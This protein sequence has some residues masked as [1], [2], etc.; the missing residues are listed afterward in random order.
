M[1]LESLILINVLF[2][3]FTISS[4]IDSRSHDLS[5]KYTDEEVPLQPFAMRFTEDYIHAQN[6]LPNQ[7]I[8]FIHANKES[9]LSLYSNDP[10]QITVTRHGYGG[11]TAKEKE[12]EKEEGEEEIV[13]TLSVDG[14]VEQITEEK[15]EGDNLQTNNQT[16]LYL[17]SCVTDKLHNFIRNLVGTVA[18]QERSSFSELWTPDGLQVF[19]IFFFLFCFFG[20]YIYIYISIY[21]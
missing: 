15:E 10:S 7:L 2:S 18:T 14:S 17:N 21:A 20:V 13:A 5:A 9:C 4:S 8:S 3:L 16:V 12:K 11:F 1:A 6:A 19:L